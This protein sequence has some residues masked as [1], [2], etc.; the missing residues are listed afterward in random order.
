MNWAEVIDHIKKEYTT[1]EFYEPSYDRKQILKRIEACFIKPSADYF[2][3]NNYR[4]P[5]RDWWLNFQSP[6]YLLECSAA[7]LLEKIIE[8]DR[9]IWS[10]FQDING[11][12]WVYKSTL[13]PI[14]RLQ[15]RDEVDV[16]FFIDLDYHYMLA[17]KTV[18]KAIEVKYQGFSVQQQQL[19]T[20][21]IM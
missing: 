10:A 21:F 12:I 11:S 15:P 14:M 9:P 2:H 1:Q 8:P 18:E 5:F 6:N 17:V 4:G 13:K 7:Q 19:I 3:P 20:S 16:T